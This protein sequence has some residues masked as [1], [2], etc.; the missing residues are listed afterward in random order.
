MSTSND[1]SAEPASPLRRLMRR[2]RHR[3]ARLPRP[4]SMRPSGR[5]RARTKADPDSGPAGGGKPRFRATPLG[6]FGIMLAAM[7]LTLLLIQNFFGTFRPGGE[8]AKP[9]PSPGISAIPPKGTARIMVA[10]D[11]ISQGSSGDYTW[12]YRLWKHLSQESRVDVDFVGPYDDML[13]VNN[14]DYG[15]H[16]YADADF[17]TQHASVWGATAEDIAK[18]IG[19]Q[20]VEYDPHYVLIMAGTNE[21]VTGGTAT[22]ALESIRDAVD[23]ARVARGDVQIVVGEL[24]PVWGTGN[25][26][27]MNEQ[28][29]RFNTG[30]PE[31]AS[32]ISGADSPVVA[33]YTAEA[34]SPAEDNWD[35][36]HPNARG[37][38][39]IA[40]AFADALSE[41][42]G[43][44]DPYQRPLPD[45]EVGP[46]TRPEVEAEGTDGGNVRL[47][48]D[49][50]PGATRYQVLQKRVQPDPDDLVPL[51]M[52]VSGTGDGEKTAVVEKLLSGAT[53]EFVVRPY[54]GD[55]A[56]TPSR[57]AEIV[58]DRDPPAA[59]DWVRIDDDGPDLVW[60]AVPEAGHFEV[61]RRGLECGEPE[62]AEDAEKDHR[63]CAPPDDKGPK[64]GEGWTSVA[65]V[66]GERRWTIP[67]GGPGY[68]FAVRSHR[69]YAKGGFSDPIT[70]RPDD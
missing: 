10:G 55:D 9:E 51:P 57:P 36:T 35:T 31:L 62:P 18:G 41:H 47:R 16:S 33:A 69:D 59:P 27:E 26:D 37:E 58:V 5:I 66:S 22:D 13:D 42:L 34:Y 6:L 60:A 11:S 46:Q 12:R 61:W 49:P 56:G 52:E 68:E 1:G 45:V 50:V 44:G 19:E 65:V 4:P 3:T 67:G 2:L 53:Y 20:V 25:D 17:D 28:V 54:K 70:F 40:A 24:T 30:L 48:W 15:D 38:V 23:T 32:E 39:K 7:F 63:E 8:A 14:G 21:L 29:A 64:T 43:L